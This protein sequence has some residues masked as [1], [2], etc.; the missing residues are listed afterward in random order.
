MMFGSPA[1]VDPNQDVN[2]ALN[3]S[4]T[5]S[6]DSLRFGVWFTSLSGPKS[7]CVSSTELIMH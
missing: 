2:P 1:W 5:R 3:S 7:G 4:W 6:Q